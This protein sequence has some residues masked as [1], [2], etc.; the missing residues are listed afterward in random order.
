MLP[1]DFANIRFRRQW[2]RNQHCP[3]DYR[4]HQ[5]KKKSTTTLAI[6][7]AQLIHVE[8]IAFR[9]LASIWRHRRKYVVEAIR[10][11]Y[12]FFVETR[13]RGRI[14]VAEKLFVFVFN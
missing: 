3:F 4:T 6:A 14:V 8:R 12:G 10:D 7:V 1:Q 9:S 11:D 13:V 5:P 2:Q